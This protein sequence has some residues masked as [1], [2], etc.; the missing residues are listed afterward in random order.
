MKSL[1]HSPSL[2]DTR[3]FCTRMYIMVLLKGCKN[4]D[5][6]KGN[7]LIHNNNIE[8]IMSSYC[9]I[10]ATFFLLKL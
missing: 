7:V 3:Q 4:P 8:I 2:L 1:F 6:S 5:L 9:S 10:V